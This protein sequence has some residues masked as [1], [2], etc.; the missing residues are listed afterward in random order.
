MSNYIRSNNSMES[1]YEIKRR[2][3]PLKATVFKCLN[4]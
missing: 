2:F 3:S 4:I 1:K